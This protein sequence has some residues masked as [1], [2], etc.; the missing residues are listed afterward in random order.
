MTKQQTNS[1]GLWARTTKALGKLWHGMI[2]LPDQPT[3][4]QLVRDFPRFPPF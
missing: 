3:Q 2:A 4:R 1:T